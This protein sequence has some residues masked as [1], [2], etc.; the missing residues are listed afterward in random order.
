MSFMISDRYLLRVDHSWHKDYVTQ[1][2]VYWNLANN[3]LQV[4]KITIKANWNS[5]L[6]PLKRFL[7]SGRSFI[8]KRKKTALG[9][10]LDKVTLKECVEMLYRSYFIF[11]GNQTGSNEDFASKKN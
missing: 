2:L 10:W 5:N 1:F 3:Q 11:T 9:K 7:I 8:K 6:A 4:S